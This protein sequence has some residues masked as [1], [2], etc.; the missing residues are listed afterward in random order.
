MN[1]ET[2]GE[3]IK[4]GRIQKKY[5]QRELACL[6]DINVTYLSKLENDNA[7]YPASQK[8]IRSLA[9]ILDL[10]FKKLIYLSGRITPE[11]QKIIDYLI[12]QYQEF[13]I[14]LR[15]MKS[16]PDFASFIFNLQGSKRTG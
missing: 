11:D 10:D 2:F 6:I 15:R 3:L 5:A 9:K 7:D 12:K 16:D 8:V 4:Q 14:L 13:P 1:K